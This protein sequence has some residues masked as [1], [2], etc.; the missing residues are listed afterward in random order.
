MTSEGQG[1]AEDRSVLDRP[2][3][4]PDRV[5]S[6]GADPGQVADL[7]R[8]TGPERGSVVLIHGGFWRPDYDR[9]HL[10]PMAAALADLGYLVLLPEYARRPGDPDAALSDLRLALAEAPTVLPGQPPVVIGHSAGGHLA[11]VLAGDPQPP[12]VGVLALAPVADLADAERADLDGGA[13][14]DFLGG[15]AW[16]RADL[17]PCRRDAPHVPTRVIH[18][19]SDAIVPVRLSET[20]AARTKTPLSA[21]AGTGHFALIDPQSDAWPTVLAEVTALAGRRVLND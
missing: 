7:Y 3:R 10:R 14:R 15:A 8:A 18:G 5:W 20:Y 21:L 11:L 13:V 4:D 16:L 2:A 17:D 6:Y 12:A 19:M 9:T 1:G